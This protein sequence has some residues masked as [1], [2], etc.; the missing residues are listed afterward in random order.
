M[1]LSV[2]KLVRSAVVLG[3][4]G[5]CAWPVSKDSGDDKKVAALPE[6]SATQLAPKSPPPLSRDPFRGPAPKKIKKPGATR[7]KTLANDNTGG[8]KTGPGAVPGHGAAVAK[9]AAAVPKDPLTVFVLNATSVR[10]TNRFAVINGHLYSEG[11]TLKGQ[12]S[13]QPAYVVTKIAAY[14][15][16]LGCQGQRVEL[17][18]KDAP[19]PKAAAARGAPPTAKLPSAR[20]PSAPII[21][22]IPTT[23]ARYD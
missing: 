2:A 10:D 20:G 18:Y 22:S 7:S 9:G 12:D 16:V 17:K 15:V 14:S 19:V 23:T 8:A 4:V 5:Y 11:E 13:S 1:E 3:V 6:I 21:N